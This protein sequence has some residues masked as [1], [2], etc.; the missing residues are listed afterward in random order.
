MQEPKPMIVDFRTH[1][2]PPFLK[3]RRAE[4]IARDTT[5]ATLFADPRA[6]MATA[7][8][9][10]AAMDAAEVDKAVVLG[11]G[12]TDPELA[13][14]ANDYLLESASRHRQRLIPFCSVNPA[15]REDALREVE[16]CAALGAK[17]VGE[18][19]PDTQGFDLSSAQVMGPLMDVIRQHRLILLTH[20]SEPVG[21]NYHGKGATTP[22]VLLGL[23][24]QYPDVPIVCAHWGGGL[25][26]YGLMPE[27]G[28]AMENAYFD[29]AA[30]PLLYRPEVFSV[31]AQLV[32]ADHILLG[33]DYPLLNPE[34]VIGQGNGQPLAEAEKQAILGANAAR[35]LSLPEG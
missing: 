1:I 15:W 13:R 12:W 20:S 30:S 29:S 10:I 31:A 18:L 4:Y 25:P 5:L 22:D 32:G 28:A 11:V 24:R 34:R 21:H 6:P 2:V 3:E 33:S 23:I 8:E 17:G 16:R 35:L 19:H 9:L 7:E 26:F 14:Q 27:V